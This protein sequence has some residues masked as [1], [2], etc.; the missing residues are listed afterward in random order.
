VSRP[1]V[2]ALGNDLLGDDGIGLIAARRLKA[3]LPPGVDVEETA[4][5]GLDLL[6]LLEGRERALLLDAIVTGRR[7][8]GTVVEL[9]R[10]DF[11]G[12]NL[13]SPH[14]A[15]LPDVLAL[16]DC[17]KMPFPRDLRVLAME[18]DPPGVIGARLS[19]SVEEAL[20][21]YLDRARRLILGW[22]PAV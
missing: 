13:P 4:S 2:L 14:Y 15:G 17:L 22:A 5:G 20:P 7:P 3:D 18:V 1:L 12:G 11:A 21:G 8:P 10:E 9:T 6:D 16:A 19:P